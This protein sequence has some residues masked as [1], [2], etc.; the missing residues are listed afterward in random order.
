MVQRFPPFPRVVSDGC[1]SSARGQVRPCAPTYPFFRPPVQPDEIGRLGNYRILR[2]LGAG[3]MGYV[4]RAEDM[5][6]GRPVALKVMKPDMDGQ[7]DSCQRF[8]REARA[9]AAIKHES[10]VTVFQVAQEN[11]VVFLAMELLEGESLEDWLL[12]CGPPDL[13]TILC[14][15]QDIASGLVAIH[16]ANL[17]HRDVKPANLWM[18]APE[19]RVKILDFGL[20]RFVKDDVKLTQPGMVLGTPSFM[21][22]EQARGETV[23]ARGDL[24]SFGCVLYCLCT[25]HSPFE[26]NTLSAVLTALA[27]FDPCPVDQLNPTIPK[28]LARLITWLLEKKPANR[29]ASAGVVLECLRQI[30]SGSPA[31][32]KT[33]AKPIKGIHPDP[34]A[35]WPPGKVRHSTKKLKRTGDRKKRRRRSHWALLSMAIILTGAGILGLAWAGW[36]LFRSDGRDTPAHPFMSGLLGQKVV[37]LSTLNPISKQNWPFLPPR[38]PGMPPFKPIGIRIEGKEL[39]FGIFMHPPHPREGSAN[40][41]YR[42]GKDFATFTAEVSLHDGP[43]NSETPL[44]FEVQG[45]GQLLWKSRRVLSRAD[46]QLCTVSVEGVDQLTIA[47]SC[48]GEPRG[49]HAVW[50]DPRLERKR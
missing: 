31:N 49:A 30:E 42:L 18:T 28:G 40:L 24:F 3:G 10:L 26:A 14:V 29:P 6:L 47:V 7:D 9:M 34:W 16:Q 17:V 45:D 43:V 1:D 19:Q 35:T 21:S 44:S 25:G 4:F 46:R 36:W 13:P 2:L 48:S 33:L 32:D 39:P 12:H 27:L 23:D 5:T 20:A 8:L 41:T 37:Y 38:V 11:Q 15:G 22:P 50:I